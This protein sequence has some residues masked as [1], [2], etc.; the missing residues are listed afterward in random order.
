[1]RVPQTKAILS[2]HWHLLGWQKS[3]SLR[4]L[5]AWG[6][7]RQ[8][9][10]IAAG[11]MNWYN[12]CGG[13]IHT[14]YQNYICIYPLTHQLHFWEFILVTLACVWNDAYARLF[15]STARKSKNGERP[16]CLSIGNWLNKL[17]YIHT[18]SCPESCK[19]VATLSTYMWIQKEWRYILL[20][21][22]TITKPHG[23]FYGKIYIYK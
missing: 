5:C 17:W 22:T 12:P 20:S 18:V 15:T 23:T 8:A 13:Q 3:R 14:I 16:V 4:P 1:M 21:K 9:S 19:N 7:G 11:N 2:C 6:Y 10:D